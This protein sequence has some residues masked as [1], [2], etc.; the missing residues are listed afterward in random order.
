V[1]RFG[2]VVLSYKPVVGK[3]EAKRVLLGVGW[4][5]ILKWVL[6]KRVGLDYYGSW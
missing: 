4:R 2:D 1:A 5:I 3:R 6:K